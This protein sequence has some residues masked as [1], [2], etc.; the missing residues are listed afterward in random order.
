MAQTLDVMRDSSDDDVIVCVL[1]MY[2]CECA[3]VNAT[4]YLTVSAGTLRAIWSSRA[5]K[6]AILG[7]VGVLAICLP[8]A[9]VT[10]SLRCTLQGQVEEQN[11]RR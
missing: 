3:R 8:A 6:K 7:P 10:G 1:F 2:L 4:C 9:N 11:R 5:D